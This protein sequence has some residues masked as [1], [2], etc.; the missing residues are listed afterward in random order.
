MATSMSSS[1]GEF[2]SPQSSATPWLTVIAA[3]DRLCR[4]KRC[5]AMVFE[6]Q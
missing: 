1:R 2:T 6:A 4:Q 3:S 5:G